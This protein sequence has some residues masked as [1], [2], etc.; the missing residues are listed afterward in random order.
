[1]AYQTAAMREQGMQGVIDDLTLTLASDGTPV[2]IRFHATGS[3]TSGA[4]A[5][6][7]VSID[8]V[9]DVSRFGEAITITS[10]K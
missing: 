9:I 7:K 5:D 3:F 6:R 8:S 1:M 4:L 2:G 10:P